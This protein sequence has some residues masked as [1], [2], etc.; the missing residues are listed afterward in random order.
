MLHGHNLPLSE[1]QAYKSYY[2]R[3]LILVADSMKDGMNLRSIFSD[4][5]T[6]ERGVQING[7][8]LWVKPYDPNPLIVFNPGTQHSFVIGDIIKAPTMERFFEF[9][10]YNSRLY[11]YSQDMIYEVNNQKPYPLIKFFYS[12]RTI[13]DIESTYAII[14]DG[15]FTQEI[16]EELWNDLTVDRIW[17]Q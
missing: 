8:S 1:N 13:P 5:I 7:C 9:V 11:P 10:L 4:F 17:E 14:E 3:V 6:I 16:Y 2:A 12:Q 15:N